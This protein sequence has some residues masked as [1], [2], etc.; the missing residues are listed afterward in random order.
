MEEQELLPYNNFEED[1]QSLK[2][3]D[4][5]F[6][7]RVVVLMG[8]MKGVTREFEDDV[9]ERKGRGLGWVVGRMR[10]RMS[11]RMMTLMV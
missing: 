8:V 1:L 11:M 2:L 10:M 3:F 9:K 4:Q 6:E 7:D 5:A